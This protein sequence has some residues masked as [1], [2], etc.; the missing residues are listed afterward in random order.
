MPTPIRF[1]WPLAVAILCWALN[2][3]ALK[4]LYNA[5]LLSA[6][7]LAW[8]R[9]LVM[10]GG[11]VVL[12]VANKE[13][14]RLPKQDAGKLLWFGFLT[15]GLY[16][17]LFLEGMRYA[18]PAEGAIT[19]NTSPIMTLFIT[20][21]LGQERLKLGSVFGAVLALSGV[22]LV[23]V[24][25]LGGAHFVGYV[26]LVVSALVWAYAIAIM[27]PLLN[28]YSPLRLMTLSMSG[29]LPVM[30]GY[31]LI[32]DGGALPTNM[33]T[34]GWIAFGHVALLSGILAFLLYYRGVHDVGAAGAALYM[35]FTPPLTALLEWLITGH[36]LAPIQFAG[37]V[38][39]IV[40]VALAQHY[41]SPLAVASAPCEPA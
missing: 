10:Y 31:W 28:R 12:C 1:S 13:S 22:A 36:V 9:Y 26:L 29:G 37:L 34:I 11:L 19:L 41:R 27:R 33:N 18:G 20:A 25:K 8:F 14:L 30:L 21:A 39:V 40:G 3:I 4:H 6:S 24:P 5:H 32:R 38:V 16:M 23:A 35:Y 15:M 7:Q 17:L 2:F